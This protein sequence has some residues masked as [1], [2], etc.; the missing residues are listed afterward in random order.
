MVK[1]AE[2]QW[3]SGRRSFA[4]PAPFPATTRLLAAAEWAGCCELLQDLTQVI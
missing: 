2:S 3:D 1:T 4:R